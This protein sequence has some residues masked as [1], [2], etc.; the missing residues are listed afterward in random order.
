[1]LQHNQHYFSRSSNGCLA[2][3][4]RVKFPIKANLNDELRDD[5]H[6]AITLASMPPMPSSWYEDFSRRPWFPASRKQHSFLCLASDFNSSISTTLPEYPADERSIPSLAA[7]AAPKRIQKPPVLMRPIT[8]SNLA[9]SPL[10]Q[11]ITCMTTNHT[12]A[13]CARGPRNLRDDPPLHML[14]LY[15]NIQHQ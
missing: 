2:R 15:L 14:C 3:P 7:T 5:L 10:G 12:A 11:S 8:V 4:M 13:K 9:F 6:Q 1:M